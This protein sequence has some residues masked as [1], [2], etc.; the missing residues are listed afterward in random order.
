M[1][2]F[3]HGNRGYA[4]RGFREESYMYC[5]NCG[6]QL[7]EGIHFCKYCGMAV[8]RSESS[9]LKRTDDYGIKKAGEFEEK[10]PISDAAALKRKRKIKSM[11]AL[12][13]I[14]ITVIAVWAVKKDTDSD[15]VMNSYSLPE[16]PDM[17]MLN[18]YEYGYGYNESMG[19]Y[20]YHNMSVS[21][22]LVDGQNCLTLPKECRNV[23]LAENGTIAIKDNDSSGVLIYREG[24]QIGEIPKPVEYFVLCGSGEKIVYGTTGENSYLWDI[25][26]SKSDLISNTY[27]SKGISY[28][29]SMLDMDSY[30]RSRSIL[31]MSSD[32][33]YVYYSEGYWETSSDGTE[34]FYCGFGVLIAG[35]FHTL[36]CSL[37]APR[38]IAC[39]QDYREVLFS[40]KDDIYYFS[41]RNVADTGYVA[42]HVGNINGGY[43]FSLNSVTQANSIFVGWDD[44]VIYNWCNYHS[45][46]AWQNR[47]RRLLQK[48]IQN[49]V[50]C[51]LKEQ[52]GVSTV[53]L[54]WLV[55]NRLVELVP[56]ITGNICFSADET[57]LWCVANGK[58][59]FCDL[60]DE[61][62]HVVYCDASYVCAYTYENDSLRT[63]ISGTPETST[64]PIAATSD[65]GAVCFIGV[66]GALWK[67]TPDTIH[68]PQFITENA[69]WVQRSADDDFYLMKGSYADYLDGG[70]C[71]LYLIDTDG[72]MTYQYGHVADMYM[73][74][75]D[76]YIAVGKEAYDSNQFQTSFALYSKNDDGYK[77]I[78][79]GYNVE[80]IDFL[81][82]GNQ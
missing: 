71:E 70:F 28:D 58:L 29:G 55:D 33:R 65:G 57:K 5:S 34:Q 10:E 45:I 3:I 77:L 38:I 12:A 76:V 6:K 27:G 51:L 59:V 50:F 49:N 30:G 24:M 41:M 18:A 47:N 60:A 69:F 64:V 15:V 56:N 36:L 14:V 16:F 37:Y 9:S 35:E 19:I 78:Y 40:F 20:E 80:N 11:A 67:C 8:S 23:Q 44:D 66:D 7:E 53:S 46:P 22:L 54:V 68:N 63:V 21:K 2:I 26:G 73:T 43:L 79:D 31:S 1:R 52:N 75:S 42:Q 25:A 74:K 61:A 72:V 17:L 48:S 32:G 81:W 4:K 82:W 62:P 13:L 39:S